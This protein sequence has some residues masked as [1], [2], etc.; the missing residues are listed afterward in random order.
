[1]VLR[2]ATPPSRDQPAGSGRNPSRIDRNG[3]APFYHQLKEILLRDIGSSWSSGDKLPSESEL[4][5]QFGVSRTVVRQALDE[6]EREG[7]VYKI[8]GKGAFVTGRK[9]DSTFVQHAAG[10]HASMTG[11][12]H[13][14]SSEVLL[15]EVQPAGPHVARMLGLDVGAPVL[16]LDRVRSVDGVRIQVVRAWLPHRLCRGL[17]DVD[18]AD[19]SLYAVVAERYG[20]RPDHGWRTI[21]AVAIPAADAALLGVEPDSPGLLMESVTSTAEEE[22]FEYFV[23]IYR[24]DRSRFDIEVRAP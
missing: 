17:E 9:F 1:M 22:A 3:P 2:G 13:M 14:V 21:E 18:L 16:A 7:L 23:A 11:R 12:G 4:C 8:K 19:A 24:G 20:L 10:F 15:Q 5:L 6:M